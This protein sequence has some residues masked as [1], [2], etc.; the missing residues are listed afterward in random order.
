MIFTPFGLQFITRKTE[1]REKKKR[2]MNLRMFHILS[3][4][5]LYDRLRRVTKL[6]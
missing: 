2:I 6:R 5:I 1:H 3:S 4:S